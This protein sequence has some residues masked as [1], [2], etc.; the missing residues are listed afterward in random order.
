MDLGIIAAI[1][2]LVVWAVGTF[3]F[4]APGWLHFLLTV[5]VFL[6]IQRIVV[7]ATPRPDAAATG[8]PGTGTRRTG[9]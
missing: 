1:V 9:R 2:M 5:G 4:E 3:A 6:L 7:R 8:A